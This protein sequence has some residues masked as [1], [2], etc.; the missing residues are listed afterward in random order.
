MD[1]A[2]LLLL[3]RLVS[4]ILLLAFLALIIWL[5]SR[6]LR[7]TSE[8]LTAQGGSRIR[9]RLIASEEQE[10]LVGTRYA[11]GPVTSIGRDSSNTIVLKDNYASNRHAMI[12]RRGDV[13]WVED[14]GSRNGVLLNDLPLAEAAVVSSGDVIAIGG[15]RL[16]F[17][18]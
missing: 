4:A 5:V 16:Q 10:E 2:L 18:F 12:T 7:A 15:T 1:P 13:W 11:L 14:L 8:L 9:L 6:D 17:E 3:L